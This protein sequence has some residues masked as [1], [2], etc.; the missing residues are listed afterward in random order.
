[1]STSPNASTAEPARKNASN[2]ADAADK[3]KKK[4][5][6]KGPSEE[7]V[8]EEQRIL[9]EKARLVMERSEELQRILQ[10]NRILNLITTEV[11]QS[12]ET[13]VKEHTSIV[14]DLDED[15]VKAEI[16]IAEWRQNKE[17]V[18]TQRDAARLKHETDTQNYKTTHR[19]AMVLL[20]A[21]LDREQRL[22]KANEELRI[23]K[24]N[25]Y[26]ALERADEELE[27]SRRLH[28]LAIR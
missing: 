3:K 10:E 25:V 28:Q 11:G 27:S 8:E 14:K 2:Q 12:L 4:K 9:R 6:K 1:M 21:E 17:E 16:Q 13:Q 24:Q 18:Q 5:K 26:A 23:E 15:L 7:E 22:S 20:I 19:D